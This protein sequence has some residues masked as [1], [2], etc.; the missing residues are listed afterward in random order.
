[1]LARGYLSLAF[2]H[3]R[4]ALFL[5]APVLTAKEIDVT[6][7]WILVAASLLTALQVSAQSLRYMGNAVNDIDR[8]K[9]KI[10][11]HV[12]PISAPPISRPNCG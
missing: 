6:I 3:R 12:R 10:D 11:P 4:D 2:S 9:I 8:V 5:T 1:M 7:R